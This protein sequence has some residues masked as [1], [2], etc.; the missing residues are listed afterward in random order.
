MEQNSF[1]K[2]LVYFS[3]WLFIGDYFS[4]DIFTDQLISIDKLN[5]FTGLVLTAEAHRQQTRRMGINGVLHV[6][7]NQIFLSAN[8]EC[9]CEGDI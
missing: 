3:H 2:N 1:T 5:Q 4:S 6:S 8:M 9:W 7:D